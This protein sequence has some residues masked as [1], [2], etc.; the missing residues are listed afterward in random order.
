M[1]S[2]I[3]THSGTGTVGSIS[4]NYQVLSDIEHI[5]LK[6]GMYVG[7]SQLI[8]EDMYI[9]EDGNIVKKSIKYIPALQRLYEEIL[10]NAFDQTVRNG[11]DCSEI[12]VNIDK[13]SNTIT[14]HNNGQGLPIVLKE[15]LDCYIP[16][17]VFGMLRSGSNYSDEDRITGG[18]NGLGAKLANIFSTSFILETADSERKK[19]YVQEWKNNMSEKSDPKITSLGRKKPYTT[20]TFQPDLKYFK[21]KTLT[22]DMI[23]LMEK[24][25]IDIGF[26]SH[27][28]IKTFYNGENKTIKKTEDYMKLYCT[29]EQQYDTFMVDSTCERWT[30][31]IMLSSNGFNHASFVNGIHTSLGGSHVDHVMA[32]ISKEVIEKLKTKKIE[33]KPSDVKNKLFVFLKSTIVNPIFDSQTKECLKM[34]KSKFGSEYIMSDTFKRKLL[35]SDLLKLMM[36]VS[37]SKLLKDLSKTSGTKTSRLIGIKGLEDANFAGTSKSSQTKLIL[38]EGLSAKTFAMSAITVIGR[39]RFGIFPLKGKCNSEDTK[40]PLWNGEI[41]LAKDIQIGDILIGDDGN[42]RTVLTLHKGNGKMYEISQKRGETYKVNDEH[43]L[44]LCMP[45]HKKIFWVPSNYTWRTIYWDATAM[46]VKAKETQVAFKVQCKECDMLITPKCIKKH[47]KAKHKNVK[48]V[49]YKLENQDMNNSEIIKARENLEEFLLTIDSNNIIDICIE[50]YLNVTESLKR[51]LKG[52]RGECVNWKHQDVSL[53]PYI[54]GLWLGDGMSNGY[55]YSCDGANDEE[56]INY[57]TKWGKSNDAQITKSLSDKYTYHVSSIQNYKMTGCAPL[58]KLL[59]E[60]NL[61]NNKHIPIEYLVNSKEI[62]LKVL[63]GIIDSD[64]YVHQDGTIEI[65]Q[66]TIHKKLADD[67]VYLSRS[68]GFYTKVSDKITNYKYKHSGE[69]AKAYRIK[70]SGNTDIIPTILPR[71]KCKSVNKYNNVNS[72]GYINVK[73]INNENYVGIGIDGNHRFVINDFTV[74]H[75]CLN[76]RGTAIAKVTANAEICNIVKILGLKYGEKY[77]DMSSLRYG[78]VI[79]LTD[80]DTDGSHICSLILNIFHYFWPEL[81][82]MGYL[83]FCSTPIVKVYQKKETL[84]FYTLNDYESWLEQNTTKQIKIKYFKG[85]GTS[86]A[87]EAREALENIDTKIITFDSDELVNQTVNLAFDKKQT[88]ERKLWLMERYD[89]K[90]N[91][92]RKMRDVSVSD[93]INKE[94]IHFSYYDNQRSIPNVMDGLKPSQRKILYTAIKY[95]TNSE[96]KVAQFGAK[97]AEKTDYHHGEASLMG[98]V[99]NMAQ[100]YVGSNNINLLEPKGAFGCLDPDTEILLWSGKLKKAKDIEI[101]E[102]LVGDDGTKRIVQ[103]LTD[104]IDDMFKITLSNGMEFIANSQHKLTLRYRPH[105]QIYWKENSKTWTFSYFDH[106]CMNIKSKS[107]STIESGST[108]TYNKSKLTKDAAFLQINSDANNIIA[109]EIIDIKICDYMK[110]SKSNKDKMQSL[111]NSNIIDWEYTPVEI[112]PYVL[113]IWLGDGNSD[114]SGIA[115]SDIEIIQAYALWLDTIGC[116]LVHDKNGKDH[117]NS[118]YS[119]RTKTKISHRTSIGDMNHSKE[120]CIGCQTSTYDL[121]ICNWK[122]EKV[123]NYNIVCE[124]VASNGMRRNDLSPHREIL[125]QL[126]LYKNKHIPDHYIKNNKDIRLQLLAGIIDAD[127]CVK[128]QTDTKLLTGIEISQSNRL[129]SQLIDDIYTIV[130]SLGFKGHI[131]YLGVGSKTS[132]DEDMSMKTLF[133]TGDNLDTIPMRVARKQIKSYTR[134]RN[135]YGC[136]FKVELLGKGK[137]NGWELDGNHRFL[138]KNGIITHNSRI[139]GG[140][141]AA[142]PRYIFTQL[143]DIA[144]KIFDSR[145]SQL[146]NYLESDGMS[147]EP[148]WF[149]PVIPMILVNGA[150]GIGS[151]FSTEVLQYNPVDICNYLSTM[152]EDN[153]PAKNLKPWYR[154]FNGSIER[155]ASGKYRTI[156]CYE[157]NDT[158]RSL[159][160]TELPIGVWTDDYKDF[161]EAMFADKD[162]STIA[163][164]RY[165]NSDVIVNIE[166]IITPREYGKIREMDVDDLLTKFKLSSKL[167]CTNMYLFNHEGTITKYNNVYEILKEFYLIRLDFYIKRRDAIIAVL[168]YELMILSNKVKF[169]EHVKAG[170]IKLQKID[171]KSLLAYLINNEFDQDHGVYGEPIDTPTLKEF[172][173]MIDMPIRSITNENAEKFKQQQ[174]SKQEELDRIIAQTAKDM[175]KL[176]LQSVVEANNKAVDDLVAANTSS[177]PTKS[178][179]KSRRSKK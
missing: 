82:A 173:Y 159:T 90:A 26:A 98:A 65:S 57:I 39:D 110:L 42:Q 105:K 75:N 170:K 175:W 167:S 99:V 178:S 172:A 149:A 94:L 18:T 161:I 115:G 54:L 35:N 63:A 114:A 2:S 6:P 87:A 128:Y 96:M 85:L 150:I 4:D 102:Q 148:E 103:K 83:G 166:I 38:T 140:S 112:D 36:N 74:T 24:R 122:F 12:H 174:I 16:E 1:S 106:N 10:L 134:T 146:L 136:A 163:D 116:E 111:V 84:T 34:T 131:G 138:L 32:S 109:S 29:N 118:H 91:I 162:D 66:S 71:K 168:K 88:N 19:L 95:L 46:N 113:G 41:K 67:I 93:Y 25:L 104:G 135:T 123:D 129:R 144:K 124:G 37:E 70:I 23:A 160:I 76:V 48:Y 179:S 21:I 121:E 107:I 157:F 31:G 100:T 59:D 5:L 3:S 143:S 130:I 152:L 86:T 156:G 49:P 60:Y 117:E 61:V 142:S 64:G 44:T 176:D 145:D 119:V 53:D 165:G 126:N 108:T 147:I 52:I 158:K 77:T 50:D 171:D 132:K 62:R 78:G 14:V 97:V 125:K 43:I 9:I 164:I 22:D 177:A 127:G 151:G 73:I 169:I 51:K 47:Y 58:K 69:L 81:L 79:A 8:T 80:A 154:G 45:E 72:T 137:F 11:T 17:M 28:K 133:I 56:I 101:G 27:A 120:T 55:A 153:K 30:V 33:I 20:I 155:L 92:N 40:I 89:P 141:D 13:E 7:S 15:E 68:L 139:T